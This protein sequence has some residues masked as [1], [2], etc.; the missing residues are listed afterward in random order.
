MLNAEMAA[1]LTRLRKANKLSQQ[2]VADLVGINRSTYAYYETGKSRPKLDTLKK[3]AGI[4]SISVDE[5]LGGNEI[6]QV[7]VAPSKYDA[8]WGPDTDVSALS[9]FEKAVLLKL[10][11]M[12]LDEK[13][14]VI[15]FIENDIEEL[16]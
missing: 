12:N 10:R 11:L 8:G 7:S 15:D 5:I 4:Y 2:Q 1:V 9:D 3:L 13:R 16:R 14:K 6:S